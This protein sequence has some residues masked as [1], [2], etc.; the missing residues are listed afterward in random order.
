MNISSRWR[1]LAITLVILLGAAGIIAG[2]WIK[3]QQGQ[4]P[5]RLTCADL[6]QGCIWQSRAGAVEIRTNERIQ[7]MLPFDLSVKAPKSQR[8]LASFAMVNMNMGFNRYSLKRDANGIHQAHITLPFCIS[9]RGDWLLT[10]E[11]DG[12]RVEI[13]FVVENTVNMQ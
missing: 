11:L 4:P 13:P 3:Q 8:A 7:S 2:A 10:L 5:Q 6:T 1:Q 9:G 12:A